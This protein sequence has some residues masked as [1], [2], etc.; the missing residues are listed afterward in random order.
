MKTVE[1]IEQQKGRGRKWSDAG[2]RIG[3]NRRSGEK[4]MN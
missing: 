4:K 3:E 2:Y 1:V